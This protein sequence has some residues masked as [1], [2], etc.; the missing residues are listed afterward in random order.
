MPTQMPTNPDVVVFR[1]YKEGDV[2]ALFPGITEG[3]GLCLSYMHI[4]QHSAASYGMVLQE[5]RLATEEE[6]APLQQELEA[7]GYNLKIQR[8]RSV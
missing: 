1:T 5:T 6:Y 4:G 3:V 2:I 8:R 7:I